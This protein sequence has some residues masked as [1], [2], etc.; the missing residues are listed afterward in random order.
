MKKATDGTKLHGK[1]IF[2]SK[3]DGSRGRRIIKEERLVYN[4]SNQ[5]LLQLIIDKNI[6]LQRVNIYHLL[7]APT[8]M[9]RMMLVT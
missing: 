5:S 6:A 2:K 3:V 1:V 9:M 7:G 8:L 4:V